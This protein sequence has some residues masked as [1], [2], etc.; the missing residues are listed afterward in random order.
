MPEYERLIFQLRNVTGTP[1]LVTLCHKAAEV[2]HRLAGSQCTCKRAARSLTRW[3][4]K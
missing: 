2:I 4:D 3:P 1:E